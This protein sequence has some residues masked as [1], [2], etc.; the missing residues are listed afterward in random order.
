MLDTGIT[1]RPSAHGGPEYQVAELGLCARAVGK[2]RTSL[3]RSVTQP[4]LLPRKPTLVTRRVCGE[5]LGGASRTEP[6][7][8]TAT[9]AL[10][11]WTQRR[12]DSPGLVQAGGL[13]RSWRAAGLAGERSRRDEK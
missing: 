1:S 3:S 4:Y 6:S 7:V 12:N 13:A 8:P 2:H 11:N 9:S 10:S 5:R